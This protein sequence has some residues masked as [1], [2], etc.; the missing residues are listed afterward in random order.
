MTEMQTHSAHWGTFR[1]AWDGKD[2][3]IAPHPGD[4]APS[5]LL[6]NFKSSLRHKA[7]VLRPSVRRSWLENG[8][9]S[10]TRALDEE[11]VELDWDTATTLLAGELNR[12]HKTYGAN[13]IYGGSYGW[14]SAGRFH[15]A[16]SQV[17]RFLN[18]AFG[19]YVRSIN[20]YSAGASSVILPRVIGMFEDISRHNVTW[21]QICEHTDVVLAFGGMAVRNA[22]IGNGGVSN[23]IEPDAMRRA[24][25]RGT[26]FHLFA[27][28]RDDLP[29]DIPVDWHQPVLGSDTAVMLAM[30]HTLLVEDLYS[31]D[32]VA[33]YCSGFAE[34]SDHLTGI[35]DGQPRDADWAQT[36]SGMDAGKIRTIARS[37]GRGRTLITMS[38]SMQRSQYGEQPV[39][40]GVALAAMVGHIGLPGGGYNYAL[41]AMA[42]TGRRSVT[43]DIPTM[44][45]GKNTIREFIPV[46]RISDMLLNPGASYDYNGSTL[47]YPDI[48]LVYWAGGN[49]FHHHQDI[50]RLR[51]AFSRPDT[52][53]VHDSAW[54]GSAKAADFV[55]PITMTLERND[56]GATRTDPLLVAM[57]QVVPA[58]G[59]AKDD[60]SI[61][62]QLAEKLGCAEAFT[63]NLTVDQWLRHFYEVTRQSLTSQGYAAPDFESFW[64]KGELPLPV[65]EDD[66]GFLRKFRNDPETNSLKTPSG[67][68]ELHCP[69][70]AAFGYADC[71]GVPEW[72][73]PSEPPSECFPLSV[74]ANTSGTR[75]HSQLDFGDYSQ[76]QK[77]SGRE[78]MR[79]H[80]DDALPRGIKDGDI[81][82]LWN[83]RGACL[84]AAK[85]STDIM[86]G[87]IHMPTGAWYDPDPRVSDK[88]LCVHGNANVLTNDVGTSKLA[89]GCCGQVTIAQCERYDEELPPIRAFDPP[90]LLSFA[91]FQ[92]QSQITSKTEF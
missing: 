54:T 32:F 40:A 56:I 88:P 20:S 51:E 60:Y 84:A 10:R 11:F 29:I 22:M 72:F 53:V 41:G 19:G 76:S 42:H 18:I 50:N 25:A 37:L 87:V 68:I 78:V 74:I 89:Q 61:F 3:Q 47:S 33:R 24:A 92:K 17:H 1:A 67:K 69:T 57:K 34:F 38:H 70:I 63:E 71:K 65:G 66:G 2:L 81:V 77:R 44:D 8:P 49:P 36:I 28:L 91:D 59:D 52:I 5:P 9:G 46:A 62:A 35:S 21:D 58:I 13:A 48:K 7:R 43:C 86:K 12:V 82:K 27:P 79:I 45:Q 26:I 14:S 83:D 23:H 85:L 39:W 6:D 15:H 73:A 75:L 16:Q 30:C 64:E 4:M 55:L 90:P 31:H 80:P